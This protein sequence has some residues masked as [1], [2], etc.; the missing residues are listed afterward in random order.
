MKTLGYPYPGHGGL[1]SIMFD[2]RPPYP[3]GHKASLCCPQ[4]TRS[5]TPLLL[6]LPTTQVCSRPPEEPPRG[7]A[8]ASS[9][10]IL[11]DHARP[12]DVQARLR[13]RQRARSV[14][15][16]R[17]VLVQRAAT[18]CAELRDNVPPESLPC[19]PPDKPSVRWATALTVVGPVPT[20]TPHR[21]TGPAVQVPGGL[22]L[23]L[24]GCQ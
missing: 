22:G 20:G 2:S 9:R 14:S 6:L 5:A 13:G 21:I 23:L 1:P 17:E 8:Q 11:M 15:A 12:P 19:W 4:R 16:G 10:P 24:G 3:F 18:P 7:A